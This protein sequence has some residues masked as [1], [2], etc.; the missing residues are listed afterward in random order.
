MAL[1]APA[2][3]AQTGT[4]SGVVTDAST[5]EP[6]PG[7]N[8]AIQEIQKGAATDAD[9]NYRITGIPEGAYSVTISFIGYKQYRQEVQI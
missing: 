8:V 3:L 7:A 1:V 2:V 9:G 5:Q 6:L 4:L